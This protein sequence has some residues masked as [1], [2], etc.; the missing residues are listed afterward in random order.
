[1]ES[2][3]HILIGFLAV[4]FVVWLLVADNTSESDQIIHADNSRQVAMLVG[5]AGG[6]FAD[7]A[8]ARFAIRR[9]QEIHGR[10]PTTRDMGVLIGLMRSL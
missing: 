3:V 8:V 6:D 9:F 5:M 7:A 1:M 10:Q 2:I 4:A